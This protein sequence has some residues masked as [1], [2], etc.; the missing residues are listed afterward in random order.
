MGNRFG[1]R[2][3]SWPGSAKHVTPFF[4]IVVNG[5]GLKEAAQWFD[6]AAPLAAG[7][8]RVLGI[9]AIS[10]SCCAKNW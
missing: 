2:A 5:L 6:A 8:P 9:P 7:K 1:L 4:A 10:R 3:D